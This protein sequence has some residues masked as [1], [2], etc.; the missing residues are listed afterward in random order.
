LSRSDLYLHRLHGPFPGDRIPS[1]Y[2]MT[3]P[4]LHL[5]APRSDLTDPLHS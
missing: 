1:P 4:R 2:R 5:F 3:C